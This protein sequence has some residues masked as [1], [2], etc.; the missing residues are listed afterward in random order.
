MLTYL[1]NNS[2]PYIKIIKYLETN[3]LTA[4]RHWSKYSENQVK[5]LTP[6]RIAS[7]T[8]GK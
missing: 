3:G 2:I 6:V 4:Y 5:M 7:H 8:L 1:D